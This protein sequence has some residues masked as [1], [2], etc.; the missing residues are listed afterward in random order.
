MKDSNVK[1]RISQ[2][3]KTEYEWSLLP[4]FTPFKGELIIFDPDQ[5]YDYARIK[6]GDGATK[7]QNLP[8][9]SSLTIDDLMTSLQGK[10]LDAGRITDYI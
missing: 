1:A 8:F 3:H 6:I 7:L 2:L 5:Q 10:I 4:N 9:F